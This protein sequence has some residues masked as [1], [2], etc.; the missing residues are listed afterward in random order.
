MPEALSTAPAGTTYDALLEGGWRYPPKDY[1]RWQGL[2]QALAEHCLQRYGLREVSRWYW[3]LWNEPDIFYWAGSLEQY[4]C[5]YDHT[6]AGLVG[7]LAAGARGWACH[8]QSRFA[9]GGRVPAPFSGPLCVRLQCRHQR[10]RHSARLHQ[11]SHQ[12]GQATVGRRSGA[13]K[14]PTIHRLVHNVVTGLAIAAEFPEL[15]GREVILT[16]CDPDGMAAYGK[17]DNPNLVFRNTEYYASYVATAVCE[18]IDLCG[19]SGLRVDGL[20]TWAFQFEGREYFEGLRTLSTNGID[21]PVLN[22]FRMLGE[23]GGTRLALESDATRDVVAQGGPD[24]PEFVRASDGAGHHG[25][26]GLGASVAGQSP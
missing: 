21:K 19:P 6:V 18:M 8:D 2:V 15:A 13:S 9:Q 4:C 5:L 3:E 20:L 12:R 25:W 16:E 22:V 10:A 1:V 7:V 24:G 17:H 23:L 26:H 11:L 14:L